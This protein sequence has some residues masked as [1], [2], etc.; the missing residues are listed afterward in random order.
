MKDNGKR[1]RDFIV[2]NSLNGSGIYIVHFNS[3][4]ELNLFGSNILSKGAFKIDEKV[5]KSA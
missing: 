2:V 5:E 4:F 1:F 3:S